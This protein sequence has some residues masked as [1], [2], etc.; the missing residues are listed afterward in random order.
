MEPITFDEE[1]ERCRRQAHAY[2]GKPEAAFLLRIAREFD[3]L[4]NRNH[5]Q[6]L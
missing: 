1:A 4:A 2:V 6:K 3:Q 5:N